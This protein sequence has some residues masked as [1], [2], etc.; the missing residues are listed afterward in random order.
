MPPDEKGSLHLA[1]KGILH[2]LSVFA[3]DNGIDQ[4]KDWPVI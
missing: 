4:F 1:E 3:E 2:R